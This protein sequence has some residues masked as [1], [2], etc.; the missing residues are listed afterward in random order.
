MY[1]TDTIMHT[2]VEIAYT[3]MYTW[4]YFA[5]RV[6]NTLVYITDKLMG[7]QCIYSNVHLVENRR[8]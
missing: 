2:W 8:Y 4:A 6:M 7:G 3:V 1:I 5:G